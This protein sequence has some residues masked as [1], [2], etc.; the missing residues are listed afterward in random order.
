MSTLNCTKG[1]SSCKCG[2][3]VRLSVRLRRDGNVRVLPDRAPRVQPDNGA[4]CAYWVS[5]LISKIDPSSGAHLEFRGAALQALCIAMYLH[6]RSLVPRSQR[7]RLCHALAWELRDGVSRD[8]GALPGTRAR[9]TLTLEMAAAL[10]LVYQVLSD[11]A[12]AGCTEELTRFGMLGL[13]E[14]ALRALSLTVS[15]RM[16]DAPGAVPVLL[17][18][19]DSFALE[20]AA[21]MTAAMAVRGSGLVASSFGMLHC[22][23]AVAALVARWC[24]GPWVGRLDTPAHSIIL[25]SEVSRLGDQLFAFD[26]ECPTSDAAA[27]RAR[28]A[29]CNTGASGV[30]S[31]NH[32]EFLPVVLD[33]LR[34]LAPHQA[35]GGRAALVASG[36]YLPPAARGWL[37]FVKGHLAGRG[38]GSASERASRGVQWESAP[39]KKNP[40]DEAVATSEAAAALLSDAG[41]ELAALA[42]PCTMGDASTLFGPHAAVELDVS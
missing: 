18:D 2:I 27:A 40:A 28:F 7:I 5:A 19:N 37:H 8:A 17:L 3:S 12:F 14:E 22:R 36:T 41:G 9:D 11:A 32:P 13:G 24:A 33:K 16:L 21:V 35:G 38:E 1:V 6:T 23:G 29:R 30:L 39:E 26:S 42:Q 20:S 31:A 34:Q 10:S 15:L 25:F 4:I